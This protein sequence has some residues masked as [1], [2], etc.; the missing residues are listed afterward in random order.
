MININPSK[1]KNLLIGEV[2]GIGENLEVL[3]LF[4]SLYLR[5]KIK[6]AVSFEWPSYLSEEINGYVLGRSNKLF[7]KNWNFI[8]DKDGRISSEHIKFLSW[9]RTKNLKLPTNRKIAVVCFDAD[10]RKWNERDRLM[11]GNIR[12]TKQKVIAIMGN[13]HASKSKFKLDKK[14]CV[15]LGYH[16]PRKQTVAIKIVYLAGKFY[17]HGINNIKKQTKVN[18]G[19]SRNKKVVGFDYV[20]TIDIAHPISLLN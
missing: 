19:L 7:W 15:P 10:A 9:L 11:A 3:R 16:L 12:I 14:Q 6:F 13:L 8:K 20:Y 2:H 18:L 17:N 5:K 4:V 1:I